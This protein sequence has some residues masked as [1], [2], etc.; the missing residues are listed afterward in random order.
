MKTL[1]I[2]LTCIFISC[3][4]IFMIDQNNKLEAEKNMQ[5]DMK[6]LVYMLHEMYK[7]KQQAYR[8]II[9]N[10]IYAKPVR[11]DIGGVADNTFEDGTKIYLSAGNEVVINAT[12]SAIGNCSR[13]GDGFEIIINNP[14][15]NKTII[16]NSCTD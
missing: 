8:E 4:I 6:K 1:F 11:N 15:I 9:P 13:A 5:T 2:I 10:E 12:K 3:S 14:F 16:Y 7:Y